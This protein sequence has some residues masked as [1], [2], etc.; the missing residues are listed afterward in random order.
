MPTFRSADYWLSFALFVCA[1][2]SKTVTATLPAAILLIVWWQRGRLEW[3]RDVVPLIP[4]FI[5]AAIFGAFTIWF[6]H[7]IIGARGA[8]FTLSLV[9]RLLLA[10]RV[11]WFYLAKLFWPA[12]LNFMYPRWTIDA[13]AGWQYLFSIAAVAMAVALGVLARRR[14]GPLAG[15]LF[16]VGTL[17]PVLGFVNVFPFLF[18]YVADHFQYLASLGVIVPVASVMAM[19][20]A[21]LPPTLQRSL[22]AFVI[23]ILGAQT[24]NRS[25]VYRDAETLYRDIIASEPGILDGI[26]E[27]RH[28]VGEPESPFRGHRYV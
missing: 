27:P 22:A 1:L 15:Y 18:S 5:V 3:R 11:I 26:P 7:E 13:S 9:E 25:A 6:E 28:R 20:T 12:G 24:W 4:W 19:S 17:V 21:R 10:G 2:L 16:F 8:D 14:R 23:V